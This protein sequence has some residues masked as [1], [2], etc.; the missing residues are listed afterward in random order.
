MPEENV[1]HSSQRAKFFAFDKS[2]DDWPIARQN[3][4]VSDEKLLIIRSDWSWS[5]EIQP[6]ILSFFSLNYSTWRWIVGYQLRICVRGNTWFIADCF[7]FCLPASFAKKH[8]HRTCVMLHWF[9]TC[10]FK[11]ELRLSVSPH[12]LHTCLRSVLCVDNL[13]WSAR[14]NEIEPDDWFRRLDLFIHNVVNN[15]F[16]ECN[17]GSK[18][19]N[20]YALM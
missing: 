1:L 18:C 6:R 3:I 5:I 13:A 15:P 20:T 16:R 9:K 2:T 10:G 17:D 14:E 4:S 12:L 19:E 7:V 11:W 8:P